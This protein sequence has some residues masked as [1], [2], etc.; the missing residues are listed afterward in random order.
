MKNK[1]D[2]KYLTEQ[3][4][5]YLGNKR[6]L[7]DFIEYAVKEVQTAL[8]KDKL[9]I[10]DIFSGSGVVSRLMKKYA[11]RLYVNDLE[12]YSKTINKVTLFVF[13]QKKFRKLSEC[14]VVE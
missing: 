1:D 14:F 3:I 10:V 13:K 5:T 7:L 12:S 8:G 6:S 11:R 4:I 9:D 2:Q